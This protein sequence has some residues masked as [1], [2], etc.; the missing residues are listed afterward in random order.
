MARRLG[1]KNCRAPGDRLRPTGTARP[2]PLVEP[3]KSNYIA[4]SCDGAKIQLYTTFEGKL[5]G[6]D[7]TQLKKE[8]VQ[9]LDEP[10]AYLQNTGPTEFRIGMGSD[11]FGP[12]ATAAPLERYP[13]NGRIQEVAIYR[14]VLTWERII[15]HF[16]AALKEI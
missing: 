7:L 11:S 2:A 15:S 13:F 12:F 4:V 16:S 14:E 1:V 8:S 9:A 6:I 10:V 3:N 5:S